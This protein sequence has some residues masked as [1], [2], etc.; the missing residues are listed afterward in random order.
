M[1]GLRL[2]QAVLELTGVLQIRRRAIDVIEESF[3]VYW[4]KSSAVSQAAG[5]RDFSGGRDFPVPVDEKFGPFS[6]WFQDVE[7]FR[8]VGRT[9]V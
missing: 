8:S 6:R 5:T 2:V 4:Q 3:A 9:A 7:A 1:A